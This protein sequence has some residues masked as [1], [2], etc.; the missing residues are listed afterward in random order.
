[1][2]KTTGGSKSTRTTPGA[3]TTTVPPA[4]TRHETGQGTDAPPD[5]QSLGLPADSQKTS[6]RMMGDGGGKKTLS[7]SGATLLETAQKI[8]GMIAGFAGLSYV[9]GFIIISVHMAKYGVYGVSLINTRYV[10]A[11][12]LYL[13]FFLI[14]IV[15]VLRYMAFRNPVALIF[16]SMILPVMQ[17][18]LIVAVGYIRPDDMGEFFRSTIAWLFFAAVVPIMESMATYTKGATP[19]FPIS[20]YIAPMGFIA[21]FLGMFLFARDVYPQISSAIGGGQLVRVVLVA[22]EDRAATLARL[23]PMEDDFMT[24]PLRLIDR[25]SS[26]YVVQADGNSGTQSQSSVII[27]QELID[28]V[29]FAD[30]AIIG[31]LDLDAILPIPTSTLP[32]VAPTHEPTPSVTPTLSAI[33]NPVGNP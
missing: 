27:R 3:K 32:A 29:I 25:D 33:V 12:M 8:L 16:A 20:R 17:I 13:F 1:M 21:I 9:V 11:G 28:G 15:F 10:T 31:P 6:T 2:G 4:A 24:K 23:V 18:G 26:M 7:I 14:P 22:K 30:E 19:A 5:E